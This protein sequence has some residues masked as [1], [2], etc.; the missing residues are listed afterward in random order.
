[1]FYELAADRVTLS[2]RDKDGRYTGYGVDY[3]GHA[4]PLYR[5]QISN[6]GST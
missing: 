3:L 5:L 2:S 1:M 6:C 4:Q